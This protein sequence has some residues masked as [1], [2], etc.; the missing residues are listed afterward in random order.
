MLTHLFVQF[1]DILGQFP[2][3]DFLPCVTG[4]VEA[5]IEAGTN[6]CLVSGIIMCHTVAGKYGRAVAIWI[7]VDHIV[8]TTP[9][10]T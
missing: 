10:D 1:Q 4:V 9:T 7:T 2:I 6:N 3:D 8:N 5:T